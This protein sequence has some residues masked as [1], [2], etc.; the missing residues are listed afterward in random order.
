MTYS[1][2]PQDSTQNGECKMREKERYIFEISVK[3]YSI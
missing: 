3:K 2:I 1:T